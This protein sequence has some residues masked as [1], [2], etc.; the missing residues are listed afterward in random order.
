MR[1]LSC[2]SISF[3][4]ICKACQKN[5]LEP[6]F[7]KR[8]LEKDFFVYS[9]YK[10]D[11]LKDFINAKYY[12]FGD[13]VYKILG[14]LAFQRFAKNFEYP[15]KVFAIPIDDHTRHQF[16]HTAIL[17]KALTSKNITPLYQ[18]L[19]ANNIVKYAGKD[20]EYRKTHKR[21]FR[22]KGE[23]NLDMILVDDVITTGTTLLEAKSV[24]EKEQCTPL[25]ALTLCDAKGEELKA[26]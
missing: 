22:Y 20:L 2:E 5:L 16:S 15:S 13:R 19:K 8:E 24:L 18:T 17:A 11:E 3:H 21:D 9:F 4:A 23:K 26:N 10:I 1:C 12:F 25:F 7:Y 14:S 6:S